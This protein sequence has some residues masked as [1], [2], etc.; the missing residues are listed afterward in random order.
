M[1]TLFT[2]D[3]L[4]IIPKGINAEFLRTCA[5]LTLDLVFHSDFEASRD[6]YY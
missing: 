1:E 6:V 2:P 3:I 5:L 4:R